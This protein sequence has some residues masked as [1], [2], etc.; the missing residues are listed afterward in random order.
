MIDK[1]TGLV[2]PRIPRL[3]IVDEIVDEEAK[4]ER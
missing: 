1:V 2:S 3:E 4:E